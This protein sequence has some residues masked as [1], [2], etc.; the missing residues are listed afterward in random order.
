MQVPLVEILVPVSNISTG[1]KRRDRQMR[2]MFEMGKYPY[3]QGRIQD[4]DPSLLRGDIDHTLEGEA[5]RNITLKI[6]DV[7]KKIQITFRKLREYGEQISFEIEFIVSLKE[8]EIEA[9][10]AFLGLIRVKDR[11]RV[12]VSFD[13][14]V[15]PGQLF[16]EDEA[17][18]KG[19]KSGVQRSN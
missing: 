5:K 9:P 2:K 10:T 11:V 15:V 12:T 17:S 19:A 8:F 18:G 14:E 13:L 3:I 4:L 1:D 6:R 16:Q 7:E